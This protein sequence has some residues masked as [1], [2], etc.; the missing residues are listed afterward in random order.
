MNA[1]V[2]TDLIGNIGKDN[3]LLFNFSEDKKFF[4][5]TT[6]GTIVVMGRKTYQSI[7]RVL[8]KRFN[9]ILSH[10]ELPE[11]EFPNRVFHDIDIMKNDL[12]QMEKIGYHVFIIGGEQIYREFFDYCDAI[13]NTVV[14][15]IVA[16]ANKKFPGI[17]ASYNKEVIALGNFTNPD[18]TLH[19]Y[20]IYKFTK[21]NN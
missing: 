13:Y 15:E 17:P 18:N 5:K 19:S 10:N 14:D 1:I 8:P 6:V 20:T 3:E 11:I 21:P 4:K 16:D 2:C 12:I 9:F 7:G